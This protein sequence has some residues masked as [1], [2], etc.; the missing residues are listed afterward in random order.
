MAGSRIAILGSRGIPARYGGFETFAQEIATRLVDSGVSVT[1]FCENDGPK[2]YGRVQLRYVPATNLGPFSTILFDMRCL[3]H[4]RKGF[5][6][7]YMLGY[8]AAIFC[9]LPRLWKT[10]VW[11]NMD[12]IEWRR[13]KWSWYARI[14][15]KTMEW[16]ATRTASRLIVDADG[17]EKHL[18]SRYK[19][20]VD[21]SMI[22]YGVAEPP[23]RPEPDLLGDFNLEPRRYNLVVCRLEPENHVFEIAEGYK[24]LECELP[25][26]V[27]G[28]LQ[29]GNS[30]CATLLQQESEKIRFIGSVYDSD[31]LWSLRYNCL[32][33][34]HGH[35]VGG[36]NPSLLEAMAASNLIVAHDNEFNREVLGPSGRYFNNADQIAPLARELLS[37]D[38][39]ASQNLRRKIRERVRVRYSWDSVRDSYLKLLDP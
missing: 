20:S 37:L 31:R 39:Q 15:L 19:L 35:S 21:V 26:I 6:V 24:H 5:D 16:L 4:A 23:R 33:Y 8:G 17:I 1:V 2:T 7:V 14:W 25:L 10:S 13:T 29:E 34:F 3:W 32:I 38:D 30:Y 36:T 22:P 9:F 12:G 11:I 27:V 18:R 28:G